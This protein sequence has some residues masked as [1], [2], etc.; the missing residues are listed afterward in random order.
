MTVLE[1][2]PELWIRIYGI[3]AVLSDSYSEL[4]TYLLICK[5][6]YS[7]L[8]PRLFETLHPTISSKHSFRDW[9]QAHRQTLAYAAKRIE[10][11]W[12]IDSDLIVSILETCPN[13]ERV[14][15]WNHSNLFENLEIARALA[16]LPHLRFLQINVMQLSFLFNIRKESSASFLQLDT[17]CLH[18]WNED[19]VQALK[20]IDFL[21]FKSLIRLGLNTEDNAEDAVSALL[22]LSLPLSIKTIVIFENRNKWT[23]IPSSIDDHRIVYFKQTVFDGS[24]ILSASSSIRERQKYISKEYPWD[25]WG[26]ITSSKGQCMWL[27]ADEALDEGK[28]IF[29]RSF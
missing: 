11:T 16:S 18:I 15:C 19:G 1:L 26:E 20:S 3:L 17:L 10:F 2:P 28:T 21:L 12:H 23:T 8:Y 13:L 5:F 14:A 24:V 29:S 6:S 9:I 4:A 25:D 22:T 7:S 27:W